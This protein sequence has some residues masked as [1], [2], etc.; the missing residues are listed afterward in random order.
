LTASVARAATGAASDT[1]AG[2]VVVVTAI[3]D[4]V[5]EALI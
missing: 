2:V 5:D 3:A 1:A 4:R